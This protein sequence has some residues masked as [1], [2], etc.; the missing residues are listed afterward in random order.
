MTQPTQKFDDE[1]TVS[2][3]TPSNEALR[4][5]TQN[6]FRATPPIQHEKSQRKRIRFDLENPYESLLDAIQS[7][8]SEVK[9]DSSTNT[10]YWSN[11]IENDPK[12]MLKIQM[13]VTKEQI[14]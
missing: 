3:Y 12:F 10:F 6:K 4:S 9:A 7:F 13:K 1:E 14:E 8:I 2:P 5:L 11:C